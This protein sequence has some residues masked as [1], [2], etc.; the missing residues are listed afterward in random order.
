[1]FKRIW[2]YIYTSLLRSWL[3]WLL[4]KTTGTCELQR[5]CS[6]YKPGA[7]MTTKAEYSLQSSKNKVRYPS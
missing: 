1:M 7:T 2:Q 3:K 6:G 4:R 5:I